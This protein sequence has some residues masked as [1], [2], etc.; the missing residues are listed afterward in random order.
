VN[1][2]DGEISVHSEAGHS[3]TFK[4]LLPVWNDS[5]D[6]AKTGEDADVEALVGS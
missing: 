4:L 6:A 5:R 2:L 3:S 1:Q